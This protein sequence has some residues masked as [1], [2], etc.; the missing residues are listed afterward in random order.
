MSSIS[1][2]LGMFFRLIYDFISSIIPNEPSSISYFAIAIIISTI[3]IKLATLP[4]SI[5][6]MKNQ[7][8]MAE[9]Q[10]EV[11]ELQ[12][13]YGHDQRTLALKQQQLYKEK[14]VSLT[15]GCLPMIIQLVVL[16]AFYG[17][18]REPVKYIFTNQQEFDSINKS[19]LFISDLSQ[20]DKTMI[21]GILAAV[22]TFLYS[23]VMSKNP[24]G[25]QQNEQA[26]AMQR[27]M[28][29]IMPLLILISA[30]NFQAAVA[31]YWVVS[32]L[33]TIVQQLITNKIV[34]REVAEEMKWVM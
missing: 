2:L 33:F 30:R 1:R 18:F 3:I 10:P 13:K 19:F 16:I 9:I 5:S 25:A 11:K 26:Q 24:G 27:N 32:N 29:Y 15:S 4:V 28:M 31:L 17:I 12:R 14:N 7:K 34:E 6:M 23:Y 8:K 22:T 20:I 21:L